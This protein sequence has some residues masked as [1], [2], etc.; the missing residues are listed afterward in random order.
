ML[1]SK[2]K[3]NTTH[4]IVYTDPKRLNEYVNGKLWYAEIEP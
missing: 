3:L 4:Y 2:G 1:S